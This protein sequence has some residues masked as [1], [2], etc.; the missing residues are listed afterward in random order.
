MTSSSWHWKTWL[1][2]NFEH[3]E[4]KLL[5][6]RELLA[7]GEKLKEN[8]PCKASSSLF[9]LFIKQIWGEKVKLVKRGSSKQGRQ[10]F[11]LGLARKSPTTTEENQP[12]AET[13]LKPGWHLLNDQGGHLSFVRYEP[14]SFR[15]QRVVTENLF[16]K[17]SSTLARVEN[18][19]IA[20]HLLEENVI[21]PYSELEE[22]SMFPETLEVTEGRQYR[23]RG[24]LHISDQAY[25]FFMEL[26]KRRV[27]LLNLHILKKAREEMVEMA[28]VELKA[29]QELKTSWL[30][31]F[32]NEDICKHKE[33]IEKLLSDIL[34]YYVN[35]GACQ[36]LRDFRRE[37]QVKKSVELRKR[38]L[39]R[40]EKK[41]E[42]SDSVPF[43][44]FLL[45][46]LF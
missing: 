27:E 23:E 19:Q 46:S 42:K 15:K 17:C 11:Y 41:K 40:Q 13:P 37:C 14:W 10:N 35:M 26:E 45:L 9:G 44:V 28:L 29:D 24:L 38:V 4:G 25:I 31:C 3:C 32:E 20:C 30:Q 34:L 8:V 5:A 7:D 43:Q 12:I 36:F 39:Q 6:V 21:R 2:S 1:L 18:Q 33:L 22:T 16:T